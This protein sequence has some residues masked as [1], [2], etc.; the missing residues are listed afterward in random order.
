MLLLCLLALLLCPPTPAHAA[1]PTPTPTPETSLRTQAG[2]LWREAV[3]LSKQGDDV[4]ALDKYSQALTLYIRLGDKRSQAVII[5]DIGL[6]AYNAGKHTPAL[7]FYQQA[8]DIWREIGDRA[9]EAVTTNNIAYAHY[10]LRDYTKALEWHQQALAIQRDLNDTTGRGKT[11][12]AIGDAY[13]MQGQQTQALDAYRQALAAR[14]EAGDRA[15]EALTL[16]SI[17]STLAYGLQQFAEGR[18]NYQAALALQQASGDRSGQAQ[19]LQDMAMVYVFQ[20][21]LAEALAPYQQALAI[22]R[23]MNDVRGQAGVLSLMASVHQ[24]LGENLKALDAYQQA[25]ALN[26]TLRDRTSEARNLHSLGDVY[27]ALGQYT[28]ALESYQQSAATAHAANDRTTEAYVLGKIGSAYQNLGQYAKALDFYEKQALPRQ[29]ELGQPFWEG[30]ALNAVGRLYHSFGDYTTALRFYQQA[31]TVNRSAGNQNEESAVLYNIGLIHY[32]Q[33]DY[34]T[35]LD[36]YRQSLA[37]HRAIGYRARE[38]VVLKDIGLVYSD[39]GEHAQALQFCQQALALQR[40]L[41]E[42]SYEWLTLYSIGYIY[43][44]MGDEQTA[45][46]YYR[47]AIDALEGVR[48]STTLEEFRLSLAEQSADLYARTVLL[49]VHLG[50]PTQAFELAERARARSFLDQIGNN[51]LDVRQGADTRLVE[52][53]QALRLQLAALESNLRQEQAKPASERKAELPAVLADQIVAKQREYSE[54]VSLLKRSNPEYA[55]LVSVAPLNLADIRKILDRDTTLLSFFVTP[56][57]TLAFVVTPSSLQA[58]ELDVRAS[59]LSAAVV[60]FRDFASLEDAHPPSLTRL[61]VWLVAP[62]RPY[63]KTRVIGII[64]HG[65]LHYLPF[66]ALSDGKRYFGSEHVLFHL[67]SASALPF[68]QQ[69]GKAETR[70]ILVISQGQAQGLP[71]LAYA[72]AEAQ[73]IARLYEAEALTGRAATESAF[74]SRAAESDILHLAAHGQ[75]NTVNPLFSRIVLAADAHADGFLDVQEVYSLD[76][77]RADLVVLSACQ[78]QL[79]AH[80]RGDDIIGLNRAFIYAGAPT[81]IASLWSVNDEATGALMASFYRHLRQGKSKAAALQAAQAETRARYPHPYYW[82][83]FV[84]TGD[85]G[86][87]TSRPGVVLIIGVI[88][89]GAAAGVLGLAARRRRRRG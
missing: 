46:D 52:Q 55:S 75:L 11:L 67:P 50:Q 83:G 18:E 74:T 68:V 71:A 32:N 28:K 57:T 19:T 24:G 51:R 38:W 9:N 80:G 16:R 39:L 65:V 45:L 58:V 2:A 25:I 61:Y 88:C 85:A 34:R 56:D 76:L 22:R 60:E 43:A 79:G 78:T 84:L 31:L 26:Q 49:L 20:G 4:G 40:E 36:Y 81:V 82:A 69:K 7:S 73:A 54:L 35:T 70:S 10:A 8:L 5:N 72:D 12:Q 66:A 53:E 33:G 44:N 77:A 14:R 62:L 64:P 30:L 17:A 48:S 89:G 29:R 21:Q 13:I 6:I 63:L 42:H 86:K 37:V 3:A 41:G 59:D 23:E 1:D 47:Q 27:T 15:G 87:S